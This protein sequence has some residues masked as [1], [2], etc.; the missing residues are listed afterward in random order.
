MFIVYV[1]RSQSTGKLYIGQT[2][3]MEKRLQEHQLGEARYTRGKGLWTLMYKE[4]YPTR[5]QAMKREK[6][7]KSGK[8]REY[9]KEYL[10]DY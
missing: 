1:L 2:P 6:S 4:E 3:N 8:G 7:L 5:S 9:L 10:A